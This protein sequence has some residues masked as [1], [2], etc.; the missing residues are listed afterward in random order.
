MSHPSPSWKRLFWRLLI[1]HLDLCPIELAQSSEFL[2][3]FL[4]INWFL[5]VLEKRNPGYFWGFF[6]LILV[7]LNYPNDK[8]HSIQS[9]KCKILIW[10]AGICNKCRDAF[11]ICCCLQGCV[12]LRMKL[13][14]SQ[15][16]RSTFRVFSS[17]GGNS[18]PIYPIWILFQLTYIILY[19]ITLVG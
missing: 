17:I 19:L 6:K 9:N 2:L 18:Y 14:H 8:M 5:E 10:K 13:V 11:C 4:V 12:I 16:P 3:K 7:S 1:P 15:V